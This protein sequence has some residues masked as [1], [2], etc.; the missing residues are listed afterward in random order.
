MQFFSRIFFTKDVFGK[1]RSREK[2]EDWKVGNIAHLD[3]RWTMR[4]WM[5]VSRRRARGR[6][7]APGR[8]GTASGGENPGLVAEQ[9][10]LDFLRTLADHLRPPE[11]FSSRE[12]ARST[13]WNVDPLLPPCQTSFTVVPPRSLNTT[14]IF[15]LCLYPPLQHLHQLF[16][17]PLLNRSFNSHTLKTSGFLQFAFRRFALDL[18]T[19]SNCVS[20]LISTPFSF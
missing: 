14:K 3:Q 11:P 18:E 10:F 8:N 4:G 5:V 17:P 1:P 2:S 13:I 19:L 12:I 20:F 7:R 16:F 15:T 9:H 6:P